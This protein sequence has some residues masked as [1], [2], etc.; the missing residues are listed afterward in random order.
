MTVA[1]LLLAA[2]TLW[3]QIAVRFQPQAEVSDAKIVLAD[4]AT[5]VPRGPEAELIGKLPVAMSPV[6]GKTKELSTL[7]VI[8]SLRNRPE[9]ANVDWQ[10][11]QTIKVSR[12][13]NVIRQ[14]QMQAIIDTYL[15]ANRALLPQAE[16][17]FT[18]MRAPEKINL[19]AGTVTWRVTPT[20]PG[21]MGSNGFTITFL[22]DDQQITNCVVRGRLEAMAEVVTAATALHK[23]ETL[24]QSN[25]VLQRQDIGT[26]ENPILAVETVLGKQVARTV[27]AGTVLK[28]EHI[29]L[30]PVI[31]GGDMVKI[32]ARK[33]GLAISANGIAKADGRPGETIAVKNISSNKMLH[34]RVDGPSQVSVDF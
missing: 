27:P 31:K 22:V 25:I 18:S 24:S 5:I 23:G 3:A 12:A 15:Q 17:R 28:Q 19:P 30:P 16:V 6:P 21:I 9:V 7:S 32:F 8:G 14:A 26:L 2:S 11:S 29:V 33:E 20:R 4:I 34:C 13:G 10:G 1:G